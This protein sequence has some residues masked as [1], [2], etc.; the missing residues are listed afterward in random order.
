[1]MMSQGGTTLKKILQYH[2]YDYHCDY[3]HYYYYHYYYY[4]YYQTIS[5][6]MY[7]LNFMKNILILLL[8]FTNLQVSELLFS[9]FSRLSDP[10]RPYFF[11]FSGFSL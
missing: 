1:M 3:H 5:I 7:C 8:I 4:Q 9:S 11:F 6:V 2:C 10:Q